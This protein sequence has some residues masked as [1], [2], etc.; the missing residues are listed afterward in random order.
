MR[1][2]LLLLFVLPTAL[3]AQSKF[4]QKGEQNG[5]EMA[6]RWN[7]YERNGASGRCLDVMFT[8]FM[9]GF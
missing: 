6:Y 4:I 7:Y 1:R 8:E 2:L 3:H 5:V 9:S